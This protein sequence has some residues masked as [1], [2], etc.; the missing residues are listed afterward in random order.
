LAEDS[1]TEEEKGKKKGS[2]NKVLK[3]LVEGEV[4][5]FLHLNQDAYLADLQY[6]DIENSEEEDNEV[7]LT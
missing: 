1:S 2:S 4:T 3:T 6:E 7:C 5:H